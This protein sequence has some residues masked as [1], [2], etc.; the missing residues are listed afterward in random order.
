MGSNFSVKEAA[1][2]LHQRKANRE[3]FAALSGSHLPPTMND[4]YDVADQFVSLSCAQENARR[5]GY[6][7]A[8]TTPQMRAFVGYSD[9]IAG[10]VLS[11]TTHASGTAVS[12]SDFVRMAFE[13]EIAFLV[14]REITAQDAASS[15]SIA[16]CIEAAAPAFELVDDLNADYSAFGKDEGATL[17]SLAAGNAWNHGVVLGQWMRDWRG[18]DLG[19]LHGQAFINGEPQGEG[20]GRDVLGHPL[21][22]MCW[23]A[24][25][26]LARGKSLKPGEF[27]ITGS[28]ITTKFPKPGDSVRYLAGDLGE[29][30]MNVTA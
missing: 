21:E 7:I 17:K 23:I 22:A 15:T 29:V 16:Q 19:A 14:S 4:A 3:P 28:L 12:V 5:V 30:S 27:V 6:K 9:S 10:T 18:I 24:R 2:W 8:L 25:H 20:H 26:L 11:S 1:A 13:C